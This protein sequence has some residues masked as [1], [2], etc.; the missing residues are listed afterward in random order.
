MGETLQVER[1]G[2]KKPGNDRYLSNQWGKAKKTGEKKSGSSL[3][4]YDPHARKEKRKSIKQ[5]MK[6]EL[7]G[8]AQKL[9]GRQFFM[10]GGEKKG[11]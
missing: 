10:G 5:R 3:R 9:Q 7:N 4:K 11:V 6:K 8:K 1:E 2:E